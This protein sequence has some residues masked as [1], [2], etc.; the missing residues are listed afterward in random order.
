MTYSLDNLTEES[1]QYNLDHWVNT[2]L[3]HTENLKAED[4]KTNIA[5][6]TRSI[7]VDFIT[8]ELNARRIEYAFRHMNKIQINELDNGNWMVSIKETYSENDVKFQLEAC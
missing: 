8:D 2:V 4:F 3:N 1:K 5:F 6:T 7:I